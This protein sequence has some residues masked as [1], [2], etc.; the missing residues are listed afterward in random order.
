MIIDWEL[1]LRI[2]DFRKLMNEVNT[3]FYNMQLEGLYI[4]FYN[5]FLFLCPV[6][7]YFPNITYLDW[8]YFVSSLF[9]L[10]ASSYIPT[11]SLLDITTIDSTEIKI[12]SM[13]N[14]ETKKRKRTYIIEKYNLTTRNILW[15]SRVDV[16]IGRVS[17]LL[18]G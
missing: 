10:I 15:T 9:F 2:C 3:Y 16:L 11:C 6:C 12:R 7:R 1:L 13:L 5:F 4:G 17:I 14:I 18:I 8:Y